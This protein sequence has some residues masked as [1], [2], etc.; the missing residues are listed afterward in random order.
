MSTIRF[1]ATPYKVGSWTIL[2]LPTEASAQLPSRGMTVVEGTING[3]SFQAPLEPDGN[4]S[5]WFRVDANLHKAAGVN[6]GDSATLEIEPTKAWP[7]PEIPE[8]LQKALRA[9][10]AAQDLWTKI[11]PNAQW[12]WIRWIRSTKQ[13]ETRAKRIEVACSKL[14]SGM[15]RPCCFNR[16]L[17]SEPYVSHNWVLR[18][19]AE[20]AN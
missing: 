14:T 3:I 11:T 2:R 4:G 20:A 17:C 1:E 15:R 18:E 13:P 5:H 10:P 19:P 12:E 8:D 16:N 9:A 6:A 7:R